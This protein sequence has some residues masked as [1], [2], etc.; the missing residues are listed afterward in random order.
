MNSFLGCLAPTRDQYNHHTR[1]CSGGHAEFKSQQP[2]RSDNLGVEDTPESL[3]SSH[4]S[5]DRPRRIRKRR[6]GRTRPSQCDAEL[7]A[8]LDPHRPEIAAHAGEYALH[9]AS[10]SEDEGDESEKEK[11]VLLS[12]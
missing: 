1:R 2:F 8:Q 6:T 10:Q 4:G 3:F 12:F 5:G 9:S 7:I 11:A